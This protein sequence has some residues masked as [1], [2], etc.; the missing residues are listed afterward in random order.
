[1]IVGIKQIFKNNLFVYCRKE[2]SPLSKKLYQW[3]Y[4]LLAALLLL[5]LAWMLLVYGA[6]IGAALCGRS[7]LNSGSCVGC[8]GGKYPHNLAW[9][10]KLTSVF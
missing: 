1:M 4:W 3:R 7:M 5:L 9:D 6:I 2:P 8:K 10:A